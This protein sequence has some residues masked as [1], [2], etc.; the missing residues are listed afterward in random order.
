MRTVLCPS[1]PSYLLEVIYQNKKL[2]H[3]TRPIGT[4]GPNIFH[5]NY[6][7]PTLIAAPPISI[8]AAELFQ[9]TWGRGEHMGQV[10]RMSEHVDV[11]PIHLIHLYLLHELH[12]APPGLVK[13]LER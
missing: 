9:A 1:G 4:R 8:M 7:F 2:L 11:L 6:N 13:K 12:Q 5:Q 10:R 3:T